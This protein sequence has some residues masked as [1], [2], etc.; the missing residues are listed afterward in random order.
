M[1]ILF[2][3]ILL[4][5]LLFANTEPL[6]NFMSTIDWT[7]MGDKTEFSFDLCQCDFDGGESAVGMRARIAEPIGLLEFTN[8]PW[9][10]VSIN[11]KFDRSLGR[12]QGSSKEDGDNRR[13]GHFIA[14][15]PLGFLNF[16]QDF[17]C[18]ERFSSLG[19]LY[20]SEIIPTQ[21]NDIMALFAQMTKITSSK[22]WFN[23]PIGALACAADCAA[24]TFNSPI[25]SLHW[26]AGCAGATGNNTAYGN[27]K[28]EDHLMQA[29]AHSLS[30]I[31]DLH[32]AGIL[33][34]V[35]NASFTFA[36]TL[37]IPNSECEPRY[38]ELGIKS[39]Y[40]LNLA[41]PTVWDAT[42]IGKAAPFW[43]TFK[44][45]F[46]SEDDVAFWLWSIKDTCVG[47]A[48]CKSMFT[49]LTN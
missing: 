40:Y 7:F 44:N 32:F 38:F 2:S 28:S 19:F 33:S 13:Y 42:T 47:G 24:S 17:V 34:K 8:T 15:A 20:W 30:I 48:K 45:K 6:I 3:F 43:A 11:K 23:N 1:K 35:S 41:S 26:C 12:K 9:N 27:G 36:P 16:I 5:K 22:A 49:G 39:Q 21:T 4:T 37:R 46:G 31:D 25:N 18:F 29:H 10:V 14:F